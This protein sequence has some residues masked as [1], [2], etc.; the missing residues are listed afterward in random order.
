MNNYKK[1]IGSNAYTFHKL[2]YKLKNILLLYIEY[3]GKR[4]T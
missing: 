4:D 2:Y 3:D 1:C